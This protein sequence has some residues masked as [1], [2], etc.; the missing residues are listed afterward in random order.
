M[1]I[2]SSKHLISDVYRM[3]NEID[4][5]L[6]VSQRIQRCDYAQYVRALVERRYYKSNAGAFFNVCALSRIEIIAVRRRASRETIVC[7]HRREIGVCA[8]K[9]TIEW[10]CKM[11]KERIV[12]HAR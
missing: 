5:S 12:R 8:R 2:R 11:H 6:H 9:R 4:E 10:T 7:K 3:F 1:S